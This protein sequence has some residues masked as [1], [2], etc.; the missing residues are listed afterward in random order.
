MVLPTPIENTD[1]FE[2]QG[3]HG[4]LRRVALVTLLLIVDLG[5]EGMSNR[6]CGPLHERVPEELWTLETPVHPGFLAAAFGH[7]C[8]PGIFLQGGGG[9]I[10]FAWLPEGD[11]EAGRKDGSRAGEGLKQGEIGMMLG[12]LRD[13]MIKGLDRVQSHAKLTDQGLD[14]QGIGGDDTFISG[15][16]SRGFDGVNARGEHGFHTHMVVAKEGFQG[17]PRASCAALRV[18]QRLRKSQKTRVSLS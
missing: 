16:G 17:G 9:R 15:Q 10:P 12:A 18:G 5:P 8:D 11:Q 2:R 3:A 13:G 7:R 4:G 14:E 1:P 6:L